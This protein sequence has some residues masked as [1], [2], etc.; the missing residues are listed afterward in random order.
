MHSFGENADADS[1]NDGCVFVSRSNRVTDIFQNYHHLTSF[2]T[3]D[4]ET[5]SQNFF[6]LQQAKLR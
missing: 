4:K 6:L 2:E 5:G 1:F 3:L